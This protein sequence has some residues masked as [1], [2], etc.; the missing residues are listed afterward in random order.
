M[1]GWTTDF[2]PKLTEDAQTLGLID[3][4][5]PIKGSEA[6]RLTRELAQKE[7]IFAGISAGAT[8]AGAL[9]VAASAPEG[10]T[11][12]CMLPDTGERYLSTPMFD[13]IGADMSEEEWQIS[14]S[15]PGFRF[16][17]SPPA[18]PAEVAPKLL[19]LA[20]PVL[21]AEAEDFVT[22][23]V[24]DPEQPVVL[25]AH[26]W[27][28]FSGSLRKLFARCAIPYRAIDL[29]STA[30]QRD[31]RGGKIRAVLRER[32]GSKTIPQVFIGG[33]FIGGATE[34]FEMFKQGRLQHRL[35]EL[36]V[37]FD[38][39]VQVDPYSMLPAWLHPR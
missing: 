32:T 18:A 27:C 26:V 35:G 3:Q 20:P 29:D 6:L 15:T 9:E 1:Q 38:A 23:V 37:S 33:E 2:I 22:Q 28:E 34:T 24:A 10:T 5:L 36:G 7:G 16:D 13:A 30:Y 12:L 11:V 39:S 21:S 8:L 14:R 19:S 25:F 4:V 17:A 31:D